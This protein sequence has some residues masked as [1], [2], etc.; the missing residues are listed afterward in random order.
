MK[1]AMSKCWMIEAANSFLGF[2]SPMAVWKKK[3]MYNVSPVAT[4]KASNTRFASQ[5][6]YCCMGF[7]MMSASGI[8]L[9]YTNTPLQFGA[10]VCCIP[11]ERMQ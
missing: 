10:F 4:C 5:M 2:L 8:S 7:Q 6:C 1:T 3:C 11:Q 9:Y